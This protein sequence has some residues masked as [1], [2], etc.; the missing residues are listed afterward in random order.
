M[1]PRDIFL[2]IIAGL[3]LFLGAVVLARNPRNPTNITY[4]LVVLSAAAWSVGL[5]F[6]RLATD[7]ESALFWARFYYVTAAFIGYVFLLFGIVFPYQHIKISWSKMFLLTIPALAVMGLVY[8]PFHIESLFIQPWGKDVIFGWNYALYTVYFIT[9]TG[10][11]FWHL[12]QKSQESVGIRKLQIRYVLLGTLVATVGGACFNLIY[13]LLGN[14]QLIWLGPLFTAIMMV[15]IAYAIARYRLMDI[16]LVASRSVQ[17]VFLFVTACAIIG[18]VLYAFRVLAGDPFSPENF[19]PIAALALASVVASDQF[20]RLY[21][22]LTEK[23]FYRGQIDYQAL[24]RDMGSTISREVSQEGLVYSISKNLAERLKVRHARIY[25]LSP[26]AENFFI[27]GSSTPPIAK[28]HSL[29]QKLQEENNTIITE[30]LE[31]LRND[32]PN[33]A[34]Y[35]TLSETIEALAALDVA[36]AAPI[37]VDERLGGII[38]LGSKRSGDPYSR[39]DI[40][41]LEVLAPQL[42]TALE[43]ARLYDEAKQFTVKLKKEVERATEELRQANEK[44]KAADQAKSEFLSIA[45]HQLRTPLTGIKGYISMFLEGDYGDLAANQREEL[46]KVFRSSDRLTRLIDVFLNV[47]RIETGRLDV[48]KQ[49]VQF[50]EILDAVVADIQQMAKNK[51]LELTVQKSAEDLPP[52]MLDRDKIHDVVMNLV[53]NAIKYTEKGWVNVRVSRSKSLV[54]FEVR[55]SGIGIA[56]ADIDRLFQ[57]FTRAEAVTRIQTGGSGLGLFIAKK[58]VEAHGGRIWAE[59]EGEGK[60]SM[61]TF[62][63]P[64]VTDEG[65]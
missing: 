15:F 65:T 50:Y 33:R 6:F 59:S 27:I 56:S 36:L 31:R 42:A 40:D 46:E 61:F 35:L 18:G 8:T 2:F 39:D 3:N 48:K 53:D 13:P 37:M 7:L 14:Y 47:S 43:K 55:D 60:G 29:I 10:F 26:A 58:I 16:R 21:A 23:I 44:L 20:R 57:K 49:P 12:W 1:D 41:L 25:V 30:E 17:Y 32:T 64:I 19:F 51:S 45:A 9:Y 62:T 4:G 38:A 22:R 24:L 28:N 34:R 11:G 63:L 54:V 52:M 5:A